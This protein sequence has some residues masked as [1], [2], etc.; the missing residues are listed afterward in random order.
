[1]NNEINFEEVVVERFLR[2]P[3]TLAKVRRK[4]EYND[5]KFPLLVAIRL[6][7]D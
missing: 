4:V 5:V 2:N 6:Y 3:E 1:L 7:I